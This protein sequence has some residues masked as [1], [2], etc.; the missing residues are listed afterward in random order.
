MEIKNAKIESTSFGFE[1]HGILSSTITFDYGGG[2]HQGFGGF[3]LAGTEDKP[4]QVC[5]LWLTQV[6]KVVGVEKWEELVGKYVRVKIRDGRI[7]EIG[8]I[9]EDKWFNPVDEFAKLAGREL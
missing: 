5:G 3:A 7:V 6:L 9:T 4:N 1:G 2:G 8:H